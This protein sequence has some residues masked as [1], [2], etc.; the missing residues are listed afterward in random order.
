MTVYT[1]TPLEKVIPL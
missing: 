1:D